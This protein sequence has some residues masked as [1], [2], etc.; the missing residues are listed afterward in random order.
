MTKR[1]KPDQNQSEI[2]DALRACG[3]TV[4]DLHNVP[5]NLPELE[6]LPDL[7]AIDGHALTIVGDFDP[8]QVLERLTGLP[9]V[10]IIQ[11]GA[12]PVE[13]KTEAGKLRDDQR[14]W[15]LYHNLKPMVLRCYNEVLQMVGRRTTPTTV[16]P[17]DRLVGRQR[18]IFLIVDN[19]IK[20]TGI[21]PSVREIAG[22]AGGLSTSVINSNLDALEEAGFVTRQ[23]G[24]ARSIQVVER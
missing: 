4:V 11:G 22:E 10:R 23:A 3:F 9:E 1:T 20:R 8:R 21:S 14:Q 5:A 7:L 19:Y 18:Q 17:A 15:W 2:E 12:I 24:M 13:V 16:S 6:G